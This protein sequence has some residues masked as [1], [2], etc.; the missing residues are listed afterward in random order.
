MCPL[1]WSL[2]GRIPEPG[3]SAQIL[4]SPHYWLYVTTCLQWVWLNIATYTSLFD[5][6]LQSIYHT[7]KVLSWLTIRKK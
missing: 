7:C 6:G 5:Q 1:H 4:P 3:H 2:P